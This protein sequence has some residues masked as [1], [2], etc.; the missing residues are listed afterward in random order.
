MI[1]LLPD[2]I[3]N[4]IAAGEVIQRPAS[5]V[6]ELLENSIDAG[7]TQI[8]LLITNSGKSRIQVMDNGVGMDPQDARLSFERHAT[9]KIKSSSDLFDIRTMGFRGEALASIAA[10]AQ[11]ELKTRTRDQVAGTHISIEGSE[12]QKQGECAFN[13]G[14]SIQVK[15]LFY[16]VPARRKF[17]KSDP[18][19]LKHI[20]DEFRRVAMAYPE[21][22]FTFTHNEK[23]LYKLP[24]QSLKPRIVDLLGK[25]WSSFLL[26]VEESTELVSIKGYVG[27]P[28]KSRKRPEEQYFF[29]NRRYFKS[30][31]LFHALKSA[32]EGLIPKDYKPV[33]VIFLEMDPSQLDVNV[34]PTKQEVKFE[35]QRAI[36]NY[37]KV[38]VRHALGKFQITP[39]LDFESENRFFKGDSSA[40]KPQ[41]KGGHTAFEKAHKDE[42]W[43]KF[44]AGVKPQAD[45]EQS[46]EEFILGSKVNS[47]VESDEELFAEPSHSVP[48]QLHRSYIIAPIR[49]GYLLID[50]SLAHERILYEKY[51]KMLEDQQV[52]TQRQLY[53]VTVEFSAGDAQ[54]FEQM[55]PTLQSLGFDIEPFGSE[56]FVL[57]GLPTMGL[58]DSD[59]EQIILQLLDDY[60]NDQNNQL[61]ID[62]NVSKMLARTS[63]IKKGKELA[64]EEIEHLVAELFACDEP[65]FSPGGRPCFITYT[66]KDLQKSFSKRS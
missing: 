18:V 12:V 47:E 21:V 6:K 36:Y 37:L 19:E 15:N 27:K 14:T 42:D 54:I 65:T 31:Y 43:E 41:R 17:L 63:C 10:V 44:L 26:P 39:S 33:Y 50:Q 66:L 62:Q 20:Q 28:E 4:Q 51:L 38:A 2:A 45:E 52:H 29:V 56:T 57:Q 16:N 1:E 34:H 7:A 35:N 48:Y 23:T 49:S 53:P 8:E 11:V 5:I 46:A 22:A 24:A 40:S 55:L 64:P 60:K 30:G 9:S 32:Y 61:S 58:I 3:A 59:G 13:P 25:N